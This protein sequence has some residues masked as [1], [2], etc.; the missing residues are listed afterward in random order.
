MTA[1]IPV[2]IGENQRASDIGFASADMLT[3]ANVGDFSTY[4]GD[5]STPGRF[6]AR[7]P[8]FM[9]EILGTVG[10]LYVVTRLKTDGSTGVSTHFAGNLIPGRGI[11]IISVTGATSADVTV[12]T[13]Q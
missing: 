11:Q 6:T 4:L 5:L 2:Q 8:F 10:E 12:Y 9:F 3:L 13:G 7:E 1:I